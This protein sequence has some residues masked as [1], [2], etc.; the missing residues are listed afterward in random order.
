M[1]TTTNNIKFSGPDSSTSSNKDASNGYKSE[2]SPTPSPSESNHSE[3][4]SINA[5][6][7]LSHPSP[8]LS[9]Q[10]NLG[11][12]ELPNSCGHES[13]CKPSRLFPYP[14]KSESK[15]CVVYCCY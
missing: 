9:R 13:P 14:S 7:S 5:S 11:V 3:L 1:I 10:P 6:A 15:C 8:S 12:V 2:L 4:S